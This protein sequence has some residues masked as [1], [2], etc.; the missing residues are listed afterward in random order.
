MDVGPTERIDLAAHWLLETQ[1]RNR[2]PR[3]GSLGS[4]NDG[5]RLAPDGGGCSY[6]F[7]EIT[8]YAISFFLNLFRW[9]D[10]PAYLEAATQAGDYL[11]RI[12]SRKDA[13]TRGAFMHSMDLVSERPREEYYAFDAAMCIDGLVDLHE[14]TGE[15]RY[16]EAA[17]RAGRWLIGRMQRSDGS[18]LALYDGDERRFGK[19]GIEDTW[20]YDG[21]CLHA[22]N[23]IALLKLAR[24]TGEIQFEEAA[25]RACNWVLSLQS[26]EGAFWTN[27]RRDVV[28]THAHCYATEGLV[29]AGAELEEDRYQQAATRAAEWLL[30]QQGREGAF[31]Y[32]YGSASRGVEGLIDKA[33]SDGYRSVFRKRR[34]DATAQAVR[35][36]TALNCLSDDLKYLGASRRAVDYLQ[37]VQCIGSADSDRV[38]GVYHGRLDLL[39]FQL[40]ERTLSSWCT[41]FA[42]SAMYACQ[43]ASLGQY[44]FSEAIGDLF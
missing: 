2:D 11:L 9:Y 26:P 33:R 22:K 21:G 43:R 27:R 1:I 16:R 6:A 10:D 24:V 13:K 32:E 31:T 3:R 7:T 41:M 25:R 39:W 8:G 44:T 42:A 17:E 20:Y 23:A 4:V 14:V 29:Y 12:Q 34:T 30:T 37:T 18:F 28:F 36:W 35:I 38:G 15:R 19:T 5:Y 40:P